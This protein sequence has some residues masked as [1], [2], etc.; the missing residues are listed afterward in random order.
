V[1]LNIAHVSRKFVEGEQVDEGLI[2]A[3]DPETL[4]LRVEGA[5]D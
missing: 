2:R 5:I 4:L 1:L 3:N